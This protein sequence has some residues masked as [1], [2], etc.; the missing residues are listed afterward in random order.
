MQPDQIA[1]VRPAAEPFT[2][3]VT[4]GDGA[5]ATLDLCDLVHTYAHFGPIRDPAAFRRVTVKDWGWALDWGDEIDIGT[6]QLRR[7]ARE[8]AKVLDRTG[9]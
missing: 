7:L 4:W 6:D 1:A 5:S 8:Q 9:G 2:L 3:E